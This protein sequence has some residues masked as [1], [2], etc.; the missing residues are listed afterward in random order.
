MSLRNRIFLPAILASLALL[1]ACGGG[2]S[3][4]PPVNPPPS[5]GFSNSNLSGNYVFS[6]T[7]NTST[8]DFLTIGGA[9]TAD[10]N[11]NVTGGVLDQNSTMSNGLILATITS[12]TYKVGSDGRPTGNSNFPTGLL[13]LQT[14][15]GTFQ[16]DYVLTSSTHGLLTLFES[17]GSASGSLDLQANVAQGD[18]A[19]Q[20][21][22]FNLTGAAGTGSSVC[23]LASGTGTPI[24]FATVGAFTLDASGNVVSGVEDFNYDCSSS[25]STNVPLTGGNVDLST[26]P[27]TAT[28]TTGTGS[29]ANTYTF[30]VYPVDST[31]LKFIEIDTQP[32]LVG[33]V[34][35]QSSTIP[36]GNN[37]FTMAGLDLAVGGPFTTAGIFH[38]DSNGNVMSDSVEDINDAG[39]AGQIGAIFGTSSITAISTPLTGGRA[40]ITFTSGFVNGN[41]GAACSSNCI[42]AAY[43]STGGLQMLEIDDGGLTNGIAYPQSATAL[44]SGEGFGMNLSGVTSNSAE[45]DIAEFTNNNG[46]WSGIIDFNDQGTTSF[47]NSFSSMYA[48]DSSVAGRG[49]VTPSGNNGYY[50][51]TYVIDRSTVAAVSVD[52]SYVALGAVVQQNA[53]A[54]SNV[55][56]NHLT[57]LRNVAS[58]RMK[59]KSKKGALP[60]AN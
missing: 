59:A 31:H 41:N 38:F 53:G 26:F 5:G 42:F 49:A 23:G 9:F 55:V 20:S 43:P 16:F 50:L 6:V 4:N 12:G 39:S 45:D 15:H 32:S 11:G 47:R 25:G 19:G 1:A 37:V 48:A 52:S 7:G 54:K 33:D 30:D 36:S 57:V 18:F 27:G 46:G 58:A 56:A 8:S 35:T 24:P 10:G 2:G 13:I 21:Y 40:E 29:S 28:L 14:D 3:S 51:T 44:A 60:R 22:A 34:F 17:N